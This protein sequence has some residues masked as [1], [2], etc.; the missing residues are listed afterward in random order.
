[1]NLYSLVLSLIVAT[2]FS[3][4]VPI[5]QFKS[6]HSAR[7]NNFGV[8]MMAKVKTINCNYK[9]G[10]GKSSRQVCRVLASHQMKGKSDQSIHL[11]FDKFYA[12]KLHHLKRL[13]NY[14]F[15]SCTYTH[16]K[17]VMGDCSIK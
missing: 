13:N 16:S 2:S 6:K 10:F 12:K 17:K 4:A 11:V 14:R 5:E 1:M 8:T 7:F 3:M 15:V 9:L